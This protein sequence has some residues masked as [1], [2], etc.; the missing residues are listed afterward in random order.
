MID[1]TLRNRRVLQEG[2]DPST[3][4]LL[5]DVV[6]GYGSHEN[7]AG[8]LAEAVNKARAAAQAEGRHLCVIASVCRHRG[9]SPEA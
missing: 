2:C 5:L 4:V 1:P 8:S 6:L 3:A 7:P 9:R